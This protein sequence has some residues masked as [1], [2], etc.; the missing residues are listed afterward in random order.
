[1]ESTDLL[2]PS[3]HRACP[4]GGPS[5]T[6]LADHRAA[7]RRRRPAAARRPHRQL[8]PTWPPC[9]PGPASSGV[10]RCGWTMLARPEERGI[11]QHL[12]DWI[13]SG[14]FSSTPGLQLDPLSM[15]F[16]LLITGRRLADP[17]L[18]HRLHERR[19]DK[20]R[21]SSPTSTCSSRRC[22]CWSS[23]TTTCAALRR[24]G[25][26]RS[27]V[28][29]ADRLLAVQA[30]PPPPPR[31]PSWSTASVTSG[32]SLAIARCS[33]PSARSTSRTV[34]QRR[35]RQASTRR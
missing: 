31:R 21:C 28:L 25:G 15:S 19:P 22:C 10:V 18:L 29:P 20:R 26:R 3:P 30:P 33:P 17:R 16:V 13:P 35:R 34:R 7:A 27:G 9:S 23:P 32:L 24:L 11:I 2:A 12:W 8:G 5:P 1:M 6:W 14:S 4:A